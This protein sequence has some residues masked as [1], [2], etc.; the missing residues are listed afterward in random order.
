MHG[1]LKRNGDAKLSKE[2]NILK[3][4][5][6]Q[7]WTPTPVTLKPLYRYDNQ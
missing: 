5:V 7:K 4:E 3:V 1:V 6:D 2:L